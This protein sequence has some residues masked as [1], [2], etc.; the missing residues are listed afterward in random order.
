[1][2]RE[3]HAWEVLSW[4]CLQHE[5][6]PASLTVRFGEERLSLHIP[7]AVPKRRSQRVKLNPCH[8]CCSRR[9][10]KPWHFPKGCF[11]SAVSVENCAA[12]RVCSAV[13]QEDLKQNSFPCLRLNNHP[14]VGFGCI[15]QLAGRRFCI[16]MAFL[17]MDVWCLCLVRCLCGQQ[18]V[19]GPSHLC[20]V[21]HISVSLASPILSAKLVFQ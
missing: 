2:L 10:I 4:F 16:F 12:P 7:S 13:C 11:H 14:D 21:F 19:L 9:L 1:M 8:V 3:D 20:G 15:P 6:I 17:W 5:R 18:Q